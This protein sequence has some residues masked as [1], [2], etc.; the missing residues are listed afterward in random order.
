MRLK[1]KVSFITGGGVGIGKSTADLFAKEGSAVA[2]I[3]RN[4][5][6]AR[7]VAY[8]I[9]STGGKAQFRLYAMESN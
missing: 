3:D 9:N 4:G 7:S 5:D 1:N 2:I 6:K 8:S